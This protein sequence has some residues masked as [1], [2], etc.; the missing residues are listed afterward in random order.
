MNLE[1]AEAIF[2]GF[3]LI[4]ALADL[5]LVFGVLIEKEVYIFAP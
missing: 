3:Y 4:T 2:Y 5:Q 1:L